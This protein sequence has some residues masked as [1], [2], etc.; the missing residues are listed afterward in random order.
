MKAPALKEAIYCSNISKIFGADKTRVNALRHVYFS[1]ALGRLTLL[2]GPSGCGKT[3]LLS[4]ITGLLEPTEGRLQLLGRDLAKLS[5]ADKLLFRRTNIGFVF[6]MYHLLPSLSACE[7]AAVPL[8]A[9]GTDWKLAL[10]KSKAILSQLGLGGRLDALPAQLSGGEQQR[11][12]IAR[13]MVHEPKLIVCDEPTSALDGETGKIV[14]ELLSQKAL[15]PDRAII[16]VTHDERIFSFADSIAYMNDGQ[17][18]HMS[19]PY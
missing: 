15:S 17:V 7:N 1:A 2:V 18:T 8:L 16:V 4:V 12:A 13:A 6:Q 3:T 19:Y 9:A 5:N 10:H 11:V 14:M